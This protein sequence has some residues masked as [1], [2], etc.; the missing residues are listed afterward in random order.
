[1]KNFRKVLPALGF[2]LLAAK[3]MFAQQSV[4]HVSFVNSNIRY[5]QD[6][7]PKENQA[8][9]WFPIAWKGEK[10]H[11]QFVV[12]STQD[13]PNL[14][15]TISDLR[16]EN[17]VVL[18]KKNIRTG[19]LQY[20]LTDEYRDGCGNRKS[21]DFDSSRVEDAIDPA[22]FTHVDKNTLQP[23][24]MSITVPASTAAGTYTGTI[25]VNANKKFTMEVILTVKDYVLP[26]PS[27]WK[28]SLDL[29][30]HPAAIARVHDVA[31]WSTAHYN[32]MRPYYTMLAGAG[33]KYITTSII[34]EP[35]NHQTYDDFPSLIKWTK[36]KDGSWFYDYSLFDQYVRFVMS[37]GI[38]K[39]INC[40][41]MVPWK[42]S[43]QY[44]DETSGKDT[45]LVAKIGSPEYVQHW[46]NMLTDF[47]QHLKKNGWFSITRIA[48]DERPMEDMKAVI[49]LLKRVDKDWK[50]ALAGDYHAEIEKDIFDY[51]LASK[52]QF[53]SLALIQRN[54]EHKISTFYT[55]C[56]EEKPNGF[57]FSPPA[58][59]VWL[60]WYAAA[61]GFNGYLRWAYNSWVKDPLFDSRFSS[62]PAGDTYQI[63]PG[64]FSSIR[65]EKMIEG[66]QDYEKINILR[67]EFIRTNNTANLVALDKALSVFNLPTLQKI[68]AFTLVEN[69]KNV[70]N[71]F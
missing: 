45:V 56:A 65:F 18:A 8:R 23:V 62:W 35:W 68:T 43:F 47:T 11:T 40:Y 59:H 50:I 38:S 13:M 70:L 5:P 4:T 32:Y 29:W 7:L 20:V 9:K 26:P 69:A 37:C 21:K 10:V 19:Y 55:C 30:Q 66:I 2:L 12:W 28:F 51:C 52:F 39:G 36:K 31:L 58:E 34:N 71:S 27:E 48:M 60:G 67:Q 6:K 57:T 41:S 61:S 17:G 64:P 24:W 42:L 63:Y 15:M 14:Y 1:M 44:Y 54:A 46:S 16:N 49:A 22:L 53:D 25:I 33:Q 3:I